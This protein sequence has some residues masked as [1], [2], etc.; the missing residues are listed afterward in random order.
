MITEEVAKGEGGRD[1]EG[2]QNV[3]EEETGDG[4]GRQ[5]GEEGE[6]ETISRVL[7]VDQAVK[8]SR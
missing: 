3:K 6:E 8:E 5:P 1:G 4:E 2:K 7:Q